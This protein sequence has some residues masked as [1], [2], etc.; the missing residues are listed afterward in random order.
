MEVRYIGGRQQFFIQHEIQVNIWI[1][2]SDGRDN[3]LYFL[4][5]LFDVDVWR[6]FG[7]PAQNSTLPNL[8]VD[9]SR[10]FVTAN[11]INDV[12]LMVAACINAFLEEVKQK[13][14]I[15]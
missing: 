8:W 4:D 14:S 13:I 9:V 3:R 1:R 7:R 15:C 5:R 12:R 11:G 10:E 2:N 6:R